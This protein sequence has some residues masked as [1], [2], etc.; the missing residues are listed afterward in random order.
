MRT[1]VLSWAHLSRTGVAPFA[2]RARAWPCRDW[3]WGDSGRFWPR[4]E[5]SLFWRR[6]TRTEQMRMSSSGAA[7]RSKMLWA[8]ML[9]L[10]HGSQ[11]P[12]ALRK[13]CLRWTR[14]ATTWASSLRRASFSSTCLR[15]WT[16]EV[17]SRRLELAM[18]CDAPCLFLMRANSCMSADPGCWRDWER[19]SPIPR[20]AA[21]HPHRLWRCRQGS[22]AKGRCR[23]RVLWMR[24]VRCWT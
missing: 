13:S 20:T 11:R 10:K 4:G 7:L 5:L 21:W 23:C 16:C 6:W 14:T 15:P 1:S 19:K 3:M 18:A 12:V 9:L 2:L 22:K 24:L 17:G 8:A